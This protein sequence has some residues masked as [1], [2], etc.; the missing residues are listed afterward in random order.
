SKMFIAEDLTPATFKA[1]KKL[2]NSEQVSKVWSVDGQV[3]FTL[4]GDTAGV[5]KKIQ[6]V[7]LPVEEM[8]SSAK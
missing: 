1:V 5:I 7:F 4:A 6:S 3:R 2:K 8:I